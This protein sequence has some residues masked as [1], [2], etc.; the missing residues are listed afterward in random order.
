MAVSES[1]E[2]MNEA[3]GASAAASGEVPEGSQ[4]GASAPA[5]SLARKFLLQQGTT[6]VAG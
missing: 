4:R 5:G 1:K 3:G 2:M 6:V